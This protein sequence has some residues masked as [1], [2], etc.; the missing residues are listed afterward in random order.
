M[1]G[2]PSQHRHDNLR[3]TGGEFSI[4]QPGKMKMA[5]LTIRRMRDVTQRLYLNRFIQRLNY[6][7]LLDA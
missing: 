3:L 4:A 1:G 7:A 2:A 5:G 6:R